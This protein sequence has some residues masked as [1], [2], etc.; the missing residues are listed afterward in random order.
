MGQDS[1]AQITALRLVIGTL[2]RC[3]V[4]S[5]DNRDTLTHKATG[6][7]DSGKRVGMRQAGY[8]RLEA[9]RQMPSLVPSD[10][11]SRWRPRFRFSFRLSFRFWFRIW[12]QI[13]VLV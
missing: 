6:V 13:L 4:F 1:K 3:H 10:S 5:P 8:R 7:S 11:R 2:Q 9:L 12:V